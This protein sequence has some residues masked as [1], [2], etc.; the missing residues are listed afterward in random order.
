ME[1]AIGNGN[2]YFAAMILEV[3]AQ[4]IVDG[5][6][7]FFPGRFVRLFECI[8]KGVDELHES[9]VVVFAEIGPASGLQAS[10]VVW[11]LQ[12]TATVP[13]E[14]FAVDEPDD[15]VGE[16]VLDLRYMLITEGVGFGGEQ[17]KVAIGQSGRLDDRI[18]GLG[19]EKI[20]EAAALEH[21]VDKGVTAGGHP[22]V[23]PD[24]ICRAKGPGRGLEIGKGLFNISSEGLGFGGPVHYVSDGADHGQGVGEVADVADPHGVLCRQGFDLVAVILF[25]VG[26]DEIGLEG[27]YF[28]RVDVFG[29]ADP[30]FFMEPGSRVD[31]EFSDADDVGSEIIKQFGLGGYKGN[32]PT[33]RAVKCNSPS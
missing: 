13:T 12:E 14:Q 32:D 1:V 3:I 19:G 33:G 5:E 26:D 22:W 2:L 30:G 29:S 31:A 21:F 8:R 7:R 27:S 18:A 28:A 4:G 16:Q 24:K 9:K 11:G 6:D 10:E 15:D 20:G 17:D 23:A 25:F